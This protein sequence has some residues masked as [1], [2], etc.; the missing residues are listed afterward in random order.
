[1]GQRDLAN[2]AGGKVLSSTVFCGLTQRHR[3]AS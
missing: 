3:T 2:L 1:V